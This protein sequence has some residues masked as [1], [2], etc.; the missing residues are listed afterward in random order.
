MRFDQAQ[1][2][3]EQHNWKKAVAGE[4]DFNKAARTIELMTSCGRGLIISGEYGVGKTSLARAIIAGLPEVLKVRMAIPSDLE[5]LTPEW[6]SYCA[7]SCGSR[8][9]FIDDLGAEPTINNYG[10]RIE[11]VGD[12]IVRFHALRKPHVRLILTTNL[13]ERELDARYGG[14][15]TSRL[16]DLCVPLRLKGADKRTWAMVRT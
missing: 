13:T 3:L 14:R 15:V 5:L 9:V 4:E 11:A 6:E 16:K 12:Y 7:S 8:H 2:Y 1:A 10:V